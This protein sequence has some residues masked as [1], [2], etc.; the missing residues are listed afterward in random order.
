MTG[1]VLALL[2][3]HAQA[4]ISYFESNPWVEFEGCDFGRLVNL[5]NGYLW[6]CNE[7]GYAYHY[8]T[9]TVIEV[10]GNTKL[11]VGDLDAAI[12]EFP[13]GDCYFGKLYSK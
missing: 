3:G 9:M 6:E 13:D 1:V 2:A 10:R 5:E 11:C 7:F 8:G 12:K 4:Q